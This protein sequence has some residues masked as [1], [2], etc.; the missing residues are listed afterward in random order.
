[1]RNMKNQSDSRPVFRPLSELNVIDNF[2]FTTLST[3][4]EV[5]EEFFRILLTT[6]LQKPANK[7]SSTK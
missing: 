1:M 5:N 4:E 3:N 6:F 7:K 2:P